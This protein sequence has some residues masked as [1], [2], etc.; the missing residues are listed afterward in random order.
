M[1]NIWFTADFHLN[2]S[3]ILRYCNRPFPDVE[4]M[5]QGILGQ[6][7][8]CVKTND[9]LYF[10]GDFCM[11][12]KARAA[13]FRRQIHCKMIF[14]LPGNHDEQARKLTQEFRWLDNLSEISISG[15]RI[16]LCHYAMRVWNHSSHG[17]WHLYGH[18]HGRLPDV[19][20][21]AP[22]TLAWTRKTSCPWHFDEI[23]SRMGAKVLSG[24]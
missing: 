11:G 16:V 8:R 21:P 1:A 2:H 4:E 9:I 6:I 12:S 22:W 5:N 23:K 19:S 14:A 7:N 17:A 24:Q 15:Q 13:E 3:N 10:L 20:L 18:S